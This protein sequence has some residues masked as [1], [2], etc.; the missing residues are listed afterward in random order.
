MLTAGIIEFCGGLLIAIGLVASLAAFLTCGEMAVAY[1]MQHAPHGFWPIINR[2]EL[3]IVYCFFFLYV[4]AH[5]S[6]RFS[7]DALLSGRKSS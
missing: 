6:G 5:G 3:A 4:A 7:L 2:G 1:F